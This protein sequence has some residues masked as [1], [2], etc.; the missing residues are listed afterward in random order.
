MRKQMPKA[1]ETHAQPMVFAARTEQHLRHR[2]TPAR[3]SGLTD[4][5]EFGDGDEFG[6][7]A[8]EFGVG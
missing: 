4:L 2:Q 1:P 8:E 6:E 7:G 5:D 3:R